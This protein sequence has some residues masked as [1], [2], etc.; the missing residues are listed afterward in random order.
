MP[1]VVTFG[2]LMLRLA[3]NGYYRF[4]QN[5]QMQATFGGGEANVAAALAGFGLESSFVTKLPEHAIGQAAVNSLRYF[6][7]NTNKIV[8]GGERVGIYYLEKGASQRPSVCIYDRKHSA[9]SEADPADFDWDAVFE[10]ADWFHFSGITPALS[11]RLEQICLEAVK[12]AKRHGVT[13]SF[14]TNYRSKLWS[15]E[16]AAEVTERLME[17]TDVCI[18]NPGDVK[19]LFGITSNKAGF[20]L[21]VP[22]NEGAASVAEQLTARFPLKY[23][24]LTLRTNLSASDNDF[25]ALLCHGTEC[26][27]SKKYRMHITDR[28]GGGDAFAAGLIYS[29]LTGKSP[30]DTAEFAVAASVLKHSIEG[31]FNRVTVQEVERLA[32]GDGSGRVQR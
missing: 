27:F 19:D 25:A 12:A 14:D 11:D 20:S 7:V 26:L 24:A 3:P 10:G 16:K 32:T 15:L 1:K 28:V 13:V 31:D 18:T 9:I 5:D 29:L 21:K 8:R 17:Y 6:G 23:A 2:E 22:D 30:S 4:F